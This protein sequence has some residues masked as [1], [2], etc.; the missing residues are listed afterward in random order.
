MAMPPM[1]DSP[2]VRFVSCLVSYIDPP[3][4]MNMGDKCKKLQILKVNVNKTAFN[5]E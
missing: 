3:G 2:G 5:G 1:G 4:S